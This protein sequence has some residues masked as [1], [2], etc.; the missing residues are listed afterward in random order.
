MLRWNTRSSSLGWPGMAGIIRTR[1]G[2]MSSRAAAIE[3]TATSSSCTTCTARTPEVIR[4]PSFS[5]ASAAKSTWTTFSCARGSAP[6]RSTR[7]ESR[8][9]RR[10]ATREAIWP[11]ARR[12]WSGRL[13]GDP[14]P[15]DRMLGR[16]TSA[17][18]S[19]ASAQRRTIA[20]AACLERS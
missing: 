16:R 17:D 1:T 7:R 19:L 18:R 15:G 11:T 5:I 8:S 4:W 10:S 12:V 14:S 2:A 3:R 6:I 9:G 13:S 20:S